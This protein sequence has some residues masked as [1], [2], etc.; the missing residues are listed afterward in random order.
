M[1]ERPDKLDKELLKRV[2]DLIDGK[3]EHLKFTSSFLGFCAHLLS[4]QPKANKGFEQC[5]R[6]RLLERHKE[7]IAAALSQT[8]RARRVNLHQAADR[9]K[10]LMYGAVEILKVKVFRQPAWKTATIGVLAVVLI[11]GA[12]LGPPAVAEFFSMRRRQEIV[13]KLPPGAGF[14]CGGSRNMG[15]PGMAGW[16]ARRHI[17]GG[18]KG[19]SP[20]QGANLTCL[21]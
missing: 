16:G 10:T 3:N 6:E 19:F 5:L 1:D 14:L 18:D 11:I 4:I 20:A 17:E 8:E 21:Y 2:E 9:L 7:S 15:I 13:R 12:I